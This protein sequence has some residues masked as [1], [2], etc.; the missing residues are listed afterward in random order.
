[1]KEIIWFKYRLLIYL[2]TI[3]WILLFSYLVWN[4]NKYYFLWNVSKKILELKENDKSLK[5][6]EIKDSK[7]LEWKENLRIRPPKDF[8][9]IYYKGWNHY[10]KAD[11]FVFLNTVFYS[12]NNLDFFS[13]L[14]STIRHELIHYYIWTKLNYYIDRQKNTALFTFYDK[15]WQNY[16]DKLYNEFSCSKF[17]NN[18]DNIKDYNLLL[19]YVIYLKKCKKFDKVRI[20]N[21]KKYWI[22]DYFFKRKIYGNYELIKRSYRKLETTEELITY[23]NY[24][25]IKNDYRNKSLKKM[26]CLELEDK[27]DRKICN[28]MIKFYNQIFVLK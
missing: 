10:N 7:E 8:F 18:I 9:I 6:L 16:F 3:L 5:I 22:K 17:Y 19:N 20:S 4:L 28:R 1:M 24:I 2:F 25:F 26:N 27:V 12:K 14:N 23:S 21:Y 13:L 15:I 11:S